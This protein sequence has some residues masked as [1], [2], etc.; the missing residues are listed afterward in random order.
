MKVIF[1]NQI[2]EQIP[3]EIRASKQRWI[4]QIVIKTEILWILT[5]HRRLIYQALVFEMPLMWWVHPRPR[6]AHLNSQL[7]FEPIVT[8]MPSQYH[9]GGKNELT[10]QRLHRSWWWLTF[11]LTVRQLWPNLVMSLQHQRVQLVIRTWGT[12]DR[13]DNRDEHQA[14]SHGQT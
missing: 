12:S 4:I 1:S 9:P 7:S 5:S 14:C 2:V 8:R 11:D 3:R 10:Y 6:T 13:T